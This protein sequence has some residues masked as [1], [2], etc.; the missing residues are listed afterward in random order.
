MWA[1]MPLQSALNKGRT[2]MQLPCCR[3]L[4]GTRTLPSQ[5]DSD[6]TSSEPCRLRRLLRRP[7]PREVQAAAAVE[8]KGELVGA[9]DAVRAEPA[10]AAAGDARQLSAGARAAQHP[11]VRLIRQAAHSRTP[12][13]V[14][15]Y[16]QSTAI[17]KSC[18]LCKEGM[19]SCQQL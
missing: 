10:P 3:V 19:R 12:R 9:A 17:E 15:T 11:V 1:E 18:N 13:Q 5:G 16:G 7:P 6:P 4:E 8:G 2:D 14:P